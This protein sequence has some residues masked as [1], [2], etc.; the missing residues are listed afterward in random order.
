MPVFVYIMYACMCVSTCSYTYVCLQIRVYDKAVAMKGL[1]FR[2]TE[3]T[4]AH[5][6]EG[7]SPHHKGPH[8]LSFPPRM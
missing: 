5:M 6:I 2:A 7:C 8:V 1:G 3:C 4:R